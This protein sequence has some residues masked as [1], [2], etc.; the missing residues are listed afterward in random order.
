MTTHKGSTIFLV[1]H[2]GVLE[3]GQEDEFVGPSVY[4]N[5]FVWSKNYEIKMP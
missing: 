3:Q 2:K 4:V 1:E 5:Y